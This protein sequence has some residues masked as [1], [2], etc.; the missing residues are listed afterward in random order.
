MSFTGKD[1]YQTGSAKFTHV[2]ILED[3]NWKLK[4]VLSYYHQGL[5]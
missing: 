5:G 3:G 2:W 4:T 1:L